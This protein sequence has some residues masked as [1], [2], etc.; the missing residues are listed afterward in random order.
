M[1]ALR[2]H[3]DIV[4]RLTGVGEE[5]SAVVG[6]NV[7]G[8]WEGGFGRFFDVDNMFGHVV[9]ADEIATVSAVGARCE[10]EGGLSM[11]KLKRLPFFFGI[12][13]LLCNL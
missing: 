2:R 5:N 9:Q 3:L 6:E 10:V 7:L 1:H 8:H 11:N 4:S 13:C 12:L